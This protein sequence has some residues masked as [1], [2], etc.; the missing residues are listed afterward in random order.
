MNIYEYDDYR[1]CMRKWLESRPK[2]GRGTAQKL[3]ASLRVSTVLISQI[4]SGTR[5][6]RAEHALGIAKEMGLASRETE[7]FLLLAQ[8]AQAGTEDYREYLRQKISGLRDGARELKNRVRGEM[9]LSTHAKATFYSHWLYSAVRLL[10]DIPESQTVQAIAEKLGVPVSRVGEILDF[11]VNEKL[12]IEDKGRFKM[13]IKSTHLEAGSPWIYSR[14][15]QWR[16]NAI[17]K[18]DLSRRKDLYYTGPMVLSSQDREWV[19]E[20]L[21]QL[22]HEITERA[23]ASDSQELACLNIDWF[24]IL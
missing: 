12:C 17:H 23:Q 14:Q 7:Y 5:T 22:V 10:T 21:I 13:A 15:L 1:H 4:L 16:H 11:L 20:R 3:A 2:K 9:K 6:L 19:R 18:M 8:I 24:S